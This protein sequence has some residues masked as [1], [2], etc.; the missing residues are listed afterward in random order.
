MLGAGA[1]SRVKEGTR[2]LSL[3]NLS[4]DVVVTYQWKGEG[5]ETEPN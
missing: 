3:H 1:G 5:T 4:A 2:V